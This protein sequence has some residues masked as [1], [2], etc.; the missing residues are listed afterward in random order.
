M[1][2]R[3]IYLWYCLKIFLFKACWCRKESMVWKKEY[4]YTYY[5]ISYMTL[6][7]TE[8]SICDSLRIFQTCK[9]ILIFLFCNIS[10]RVLLRLSVFLA[11][12]TEGPPFNTDQPC[13]FIF[14]PTVTKILKWAD[15]NM[16]F[17][18]FRVNF[19]GEKPL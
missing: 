5:I 1:L 16:A 13:I 14:L 10:I 7:Y 11:H 9:I 4:C 6:F 3:D 17:S 2:K 19:Q 12:S 15:K 18:K 8:F